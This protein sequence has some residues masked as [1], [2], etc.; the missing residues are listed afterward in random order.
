M[1]QAQPE[2]VIII[3]SG[4][5]GLTAAIYCAR[6]NLKPLLI[7]G[8][9]PGGQLMGTTYVE[10]WPGQQRILGPDLV[11]HMRHHAHHL[12]TRFLAENVTKVNF[13]S[14]PFKLWTEKSELTSHAVIVACGAT[15]KKLKCPGEEIYWGK[16]VSTCTVCDATFYKDKKIIIVGG[17]DTAM[18]E[19]SFMSTFTN[20]ITLIHIMDNLTASYTMQQRVLNNKKIKILYNSTITEIKG[21]GNQV[22]S[23][24][25]TD[26]KTHKLAEHSV[27]GIFIAIGLVPNSQPFK[28]YLELTPYGHIML[29][30]ATAT[31]IEG[32]FA[33]GDV[34]DARYRQ[35]VTAASTG[36]MAALDTERY[37]SRIHAEQKISLKKS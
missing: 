29:K 25:I 17:G 33:A 37:L 7:E 18:E 23:A 5:A 11:A 28:D 27:D 21:D 35:A 10:N 9:N 30:G 26:Q 20:D 36:C 4:P 15:P 22:T 1:M 6:A 32:I 16:G 2:N 12:E 8:F 31:S 14:T 3:G 34:A 19:A 13:S 24:L